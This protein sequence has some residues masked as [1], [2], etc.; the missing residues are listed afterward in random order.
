MKYEILLMARSKHEDYRWMIVPDYLSR[1]QLATIQKLCWSDQVRSSLREK[2]AREIFPIY[3]VQ[4][5]NA[6]V[7]LRFGETRYFD[8]WKRTI[9]ALQGICVQKEYSLYL[10]FALSWLIT[11]RADRLDTAA[12]LNLEDADDYNYRP[13]G[14]HYFDMG[15]LNELP[16]IRLRLPENTQKSQIKGEIIEFSRQ[17]LE[18]LAAKVL[19]LNATELSN[20]QFAFGCSV[21]DKDRF[22]NFDYLAFV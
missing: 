16:P 3:C 13:S 20:I 18:I 21:R 7:L 14:S 15:Y 9:T 6:I 11:V 10:R 2:G 1:S 22:A 19:P 17:G 12:K 8:R 5:E 4:L